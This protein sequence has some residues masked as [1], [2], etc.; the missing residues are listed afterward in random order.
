MS[1][2]PTGRWKWSRV[3]RASKATGEQA[4]WKIHRVHEILDG[5]EAPAGRVE[6][7]RAL[8][9]DIE[10]DVEALDRSAFLRIPL[11]WRKR[12]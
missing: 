2:R 9:D 6:R 1:A 3:S 11:P 7:I 8:L 5:V 12:S 4:V 10:D